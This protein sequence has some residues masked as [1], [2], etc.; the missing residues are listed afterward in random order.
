MDAA[1]HGDPIGRRGAPSLSPCAA[2]EER[3]IGARHV[4]RFARAT[5]LSVFVLILAGASVT[6]TDSGLAVPDWPLSYGQWMPPMEGGVFF[7]HGHRMI[8]GLVAT[9]VWILAILAWRA[10]SARWVL[11]LAWGSAAAVLVQAALGGLTV[12]YG[13]AKPVSVVHACLAQALFSAVVFLAVATG[14]RGEAEAHAALKLRRA[15]A[16]AAGAVYLQLI[17]GAAYRH[18]LTGLAPHLAGA[19]LA[20]ALV[21]VAAY[22]GVTDLPESAGVF[23]TSA[24]LGAALLVQLFLGLAAFATRSPVAATLHVGLGALILALSVALAA[25]A[26]ALASREEAASWA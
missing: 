18:G 25:K 4:H 7:E 2:P 15:A 11:G 9:M 26:H 3:G 8:A 17:F 22:R 24:S 23:A 14:P 5:A 6:S 16:L 1:S 13:L 12:L 21:L 19:V 10:Q 20:S